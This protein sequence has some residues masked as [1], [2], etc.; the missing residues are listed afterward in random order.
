[1]LDERDFMS[2]NFEERRADLDNEL[3]NYRTAVASMTNET[4]NLMNHVS[5]KETE[6]NTLREKVTKLRT[7]VR[8]SI[9]NQDNEV[10]KLKDKLEELREIYEA[11]E[12]TA[13]YLLETRV[14]M[15]AYME[16][17]KQLNPTKE[18]NNQPI[19]VS[20]YYAAD[21]KYVNQK[22]LEFEKVGVSQIKSHLLRHIDDG[23]YTK[24]NGDNRFVESFKVEKSE[25]VVEENQPVPKVVRSQYFG[26][27][28]QQVATLS[29]KASAIEF[30]QRQKQEK[31]VGDVNHSYHY[32]NSDIEKSIRIEDK[33][34]DN[35]SLD[36]RELK[37]LHKKLNVKKRQHKNMAVN[38][39]ERLKSLQC[40]MEYDLSAMLLD[41]K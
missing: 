18:T 24:E 17:S 28:S 8:T 20:S 41:P 7:K 35:N 33:I 36:M 2:G 31:T 9:E 11:E 19:L 12:N 29:G 22:Q 3:N 34:S 37:D 26:T 39:E 32:A 4:G 15:K 6:N 25:I 30:P 23:A 1:M 13:M 5:H 10:N 14:E 40:N 27:T 38:L 16:S 21:D